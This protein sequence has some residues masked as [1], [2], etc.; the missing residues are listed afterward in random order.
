VIAGQ[1]V[2]N[3]GIDL[4]ANRDRVAGGLEL[5]GIERLGHEGPLANEKQVA[6]LGWRLDFGATSLYS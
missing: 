2:G 3:S 1:S 5:G 6:R 4:F